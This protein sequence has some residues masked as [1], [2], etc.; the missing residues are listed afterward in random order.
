ML[1]FD[2]SNALAYIQESEIDLIEP[3]IGLAH[4][5]LQDRSG[6]GSEYLGWLDLASSSERP[7]FD[8]IQHAA[9]RIRESSDVLV[10]IGIGGSYLG[11]R[12]AIEMLSPAFPPAE[13]VDGKS[14]PQ[15]V[16]CGQNL[17]AA[18]MADLMAWLQ[19]REV[20]VNVI[21]KS[22]TTT[23]PAIAFRVLRSFMEKKYGKDGARSRIYATT[24]QAKGALR[25][26]AV[27]EGYETFV[28]PDDVGG[29]YSVLTAVGLL[30][31]AAAGIEDRKSVV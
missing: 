30:P 5:M 9:K 1:K 28:V 11:A 16:F 4:R 18:Y 14:S 10:V 13:V 26:L 6:P 2:Y 17:S 20:S 22:G 25:E 21:S 31:I 23:E 24:D 7:E 19:D 3:Q 27:S 12:A 8:R 29:R 15:I